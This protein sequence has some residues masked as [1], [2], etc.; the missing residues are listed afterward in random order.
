MYN[1]LRHSRWVDLIAAFIQDTMWN[2]SV[3]HI[4]RV[5]WI[6]I[7]SFTLHQ[8]LLINIL[9][10]GWWW[11]TERQ[12]AASIQRSRLIIT[13]PPLLPH[14]KNKTVVGLFYIF[15]YYSPTHKDSRH[16]V[17]WHGT[18]WFDAAVVHLQ[19]L[20]YQRMMVYLVFVWQIR[21]SPSVFILGVDLIGPKHN[22]AGVFHWGNLALK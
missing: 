18:R 8:I 9:P 11:M 17:Y 22:I 10:I 15:S 3:R 13:P 7:Y 20:P 2:S 16:I 1:A 6:I 21:W 12:E 5:N 14:E 4:R 19:C